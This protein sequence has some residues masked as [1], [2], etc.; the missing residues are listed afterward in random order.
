[1]RRLKNEPCKKN[2]Y[3]NEGIEVTFAWTRD[4]EDI[5]CYHC[6]NKG[7]YAKGFP[8]KESKN[9]QVHTQISGT[10]LNED[11][12]ENELGYLYHQRLPGLDWKTCLFINSKSSVDISTMQSS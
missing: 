9:V 1:M 10:E 3:K 6:G 12:A 11:E 2:N 7:H 4:I 8:K 5:K